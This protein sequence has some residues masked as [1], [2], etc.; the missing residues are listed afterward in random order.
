MN[1][2]TE[3]E[4]IEFLSLA[5]RMTALELIE[6]IELLQA[7]LCKHEHWHKE[8]ASIAAGEAVEQVP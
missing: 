5:T 8:P 4:M 6:A 2:V 1:P 7:E 3:P